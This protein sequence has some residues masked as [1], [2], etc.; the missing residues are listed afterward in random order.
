MCTAALTVGYAILTAILLE[1]TGEWIEVT[2]LQITER[3][4]CVPSGREILLLLKRMM[5]TVL[6]TS[7][8]YPVWNKTNT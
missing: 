1:T 8:E 3:R 2:T 6:K 7:D 4:K 5:L